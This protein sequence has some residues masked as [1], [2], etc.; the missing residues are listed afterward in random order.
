MPKCELLCNFIEITLR[1]GCSPVNLLH[2]FRTLLSKNTSG[3][4]LLFFVVFCLIYLWCNSFAVPATGCF[5]ILAWPPTFWFICFLHCFCLPFSWGFFV[6]FRLL[7]LFRLSFSFFLS[8]AYTILI[9]LHNRHFS[10]GVFPIFFF[11][12]RFPFFLRITLIFIY[13][14]SIQACVSF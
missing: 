6:L 2:I 3:R 9:T 7:V 10:L 4:L 11:L 8:F 12:V 5:S 1:H 13:S 14:P